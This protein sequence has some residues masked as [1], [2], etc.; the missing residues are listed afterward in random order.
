MNRWHDI[1]I[2]AAERRT[3]L[4][5]EME[6]DR[7]VRFASDNRALAGY[8]PR[9][10]PGSPRFGRALIW[11]GKQ[12]VGWGAVLQSQSAD[13]MPSATLVTGVRSPTPGAWSDRYRSS[14]TSQNG[15]RSHRNRAGTRE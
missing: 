13:S 11:L 7:L 5:R 15:S 2:F 9:T 4:L 6:Q 8:Q 14:Q 12:L 10:R 3:T 1:E